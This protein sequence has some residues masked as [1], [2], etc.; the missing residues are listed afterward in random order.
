MYLMKNIYNK[1]HVSFFLYALIFL[2][3]L[4]GL[5]WNVFI[6]FLLIII[7]ELGHVIISN[8]YKWKINRISFSILGGYITYDNNYNKPFKEELLVSLAGIIFQTLFYFICVVLY[9]YNLL[10]DKTYY[11]IKS[12]HYTI[13]IFNLLPIISLDGSKI[14]LLILNKM[15]SYKKSMYLILFIS[16]MFLLV[17]VFILRFKIITLILI[18]AFIFKKTYTYYTD[19]P[20]IFNAFLLDRHL[21]HKLYTK[22]NYIF[23]SNV[24]RI[25]RFKNNYFKIDNKYVSE[26]YILRKRFD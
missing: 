14:M 7:H 11:M 15:L 4:S 8:A 5:F 26:R 17:L 9:K 23:G 25:M 13:L 12:Y 21:N 2:S 10:L 3:L 20:F 19:I 16:S 24:N 6:M 18:C 22:N 1:I